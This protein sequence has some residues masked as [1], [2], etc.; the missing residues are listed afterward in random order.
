MRTYSK[1]RQTDKIWQIVAIMTVMIIYIFR[2]TPTYGQKNNAHNDL[3]KSLNHMFEHID[4]GAVPTGL[5]RD[6]AVED[7]DLDLFSGNVTLNEANICSFAR[8]GNLLN[9]IS[10]AAL[11]KNLTKEIQE[12]I[13]EFNKTK[14]KE[15]LSLSVALFQY[16][17]IKE[18]ALTKR[19]IRYEN[20]QV[21]NTE[22]KESPYKI[23]YVFAGCCL[24]T[25]T[26]QTNVTVRLSSQLLFS[27]CEI[28]RIEV[29]F[30]GGYQTISEN[31]PLRA[32]LKK[33]ENKI[34][35]KAFLQNGKELLSHTTIQVIDSPIETRASSI[36]PSEKYLIRGANYRGITTSAEVSI[37][38]A[39]GHSS[40]KKPFIIVEGFDPRVKGG[41]LKGF[42]Y[43]EK[44]LGKNPYILDFKN[45]LGYDIVYVDWVKS[46]EY[47]QA[48]AYTLIE[49]INKVNELKKASGSNIP[50]VI[51]GHSMGGLITRYAL[52]TMEN[53][54]IRHQT[55][56]YIS[57][58]SP[59]LGAH[60][61]LGVL[62]GFH[63]ALSFIESRGI[64][65]DLLLNNPTFKSYLELG[66]S[67]AYATSAQQMLAYFVDPAGNF[68]NQEHI[69]WQK[70]LNSL[71]FPKGDLGTSFSMLAIANG[72]YQMPNVPKN[73]LKSNFSAGSDIA[74]SLFPKLSALAV[75]VGL[76]DIVSGLLTL[77]PGRTSI[78]GAFEIYPA[79]TVGDLV[80]HI[81]LKYKKRFLWIAPISRKLFSYNKYFWGRYLY[82]TYPSSTYGI[83]RD[84]KGNPV[85][86]ENQSG[87]IPLIYDYNLF[88]NANASI[89]FIPTSSALAYGNGINSSPSKFLSAPKG[90]ASPFGENYF[91]HVN[92]M[93]HVLLHPDALRWIQ[94]RLSTSIIG[95][96]VGYDGAKY[97]L[98]SSAGGVIWSSDK[99]QIA[100]INSSGILSV[101]GKGIV[102][103]TAEYKNIR[104][105]QTI[106]VGIPR[107]ILSAFHKPGGYKI[108]ARCI[109][110]EYKDNISKLNGVLEFN[111]GVKYPNKE[112]RWIKSDKPGL[113]VNMQEQNENVSVFLQVEDALG[114]KSK[115]QH[116][117]INSQNIYISTYS[118]F[119]ID[120]QGELYD[121]N[122]ERD[123]YESSRIFLDY[124]P[125][126]P[127]KYK[128]R[129]WM[130]I[131]AL[132]L[133]PLG[134]SRE[135]EVED[136]GPLVMDILS[137][138]EFD[139]IKTNSTEN[140]MYTY[141]VV[142]L[143][144]NNKVIQ[145]IPVSFTYKKNI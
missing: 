142:L 35:L 16:A 70:E 136:G 77:F 10:S 129:Q 133:S 107:Y 7:E 3:R 134:N 42:Q 36:E 74:S 118:K 139:F 1:L 17:Q 97:R 81:S 11:T 99:P 83:Q 6:Y 130:P 20:E 144:F 138:A 103:L 57:Y 145:F 90:S 29:D 48:N 78:K 46:E 132:I 92:V 34:H 131:N 102:V 76:N 127:D 95:P 60:I 75:G 82:D 110:T 65:K 53:K 137:E 80:T 22:N 40:L 19:L 13:K 128:E 32:R 101:K 143:N 39:S 114:N 66:K 27:N 63:G 104:Y 105:S 26:N 69:H 67:M 25:A 2:V 24:T 126:L 79:K 18:D 88:I 21:Y 49:V 71:G 47:I 141:T 89:P 52:K 111:W 41:N 30:G 108:E 12:S 68:N 123:F 125:N 85:W 38:Y 98:S 93:S 91:T 14:S 96:N 23:N 64:I 5:L 87:G 8:Y 33:G 116:I 72:N 44:I 112:I 50:N 120:S 56:T 100:S 37:S 84:N 135:I 55:S 124:K 31:S 58:D 43:F 45:R 140:Q 115:L 28:R 122:K 61:P 4:K 54:N 119:Y 94:T 113:I 86:E 109:D 9:T 73:Y 106:M 15:I 59:H 62:Y 117:A 51:V 121:S